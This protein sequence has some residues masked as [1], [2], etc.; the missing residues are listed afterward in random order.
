VNAPPVANA[1]ADQT[2]TDD[3]GDGV[4]L[5]T[6]DGSASSDPDGTIVSYEWREGTTVIGFGATLSV[7]L[8]VGAHT[9]TLE[10]KDDAGASGT[11]SAVVTVKALNRPPVAWDTSAVTVVG[12]PITVT[13]NAV[14]VETCELSF[15][16]VQGPAGGA[17]GAIGDQA[18]VAGTP[19]SDTARIIYTPG[20]T[21]G[22]YSFTYKV[23]DGSADSNVATVT[24]TVNPPP[25]VTVSVTGISPNVVS[26]NAGIIAFVITGTGFANGASVIFM[27][28]SGSTPRVLTVTWNSSTQLTANVEIRAGK[29]RKIRPWDV[30]VTNPDGSTAVGVKLLTI[31][32]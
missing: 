24:I 32:P 22:L 29:T 13:L 23:N 14:D 16:V 6:L 4:A 18:C 27:N 26:Q 8:P 10:V 28:G 5:V 7:W 9:L 12:T 2:V 20:N 21:A 15:T 30:R 17:L 11:D 3:D 25:I 31:T 19:N 1:G